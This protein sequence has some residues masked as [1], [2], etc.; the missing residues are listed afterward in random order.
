MLR[1]G[2]SWKLIFTLALVSFSTAYAQELKTR[3]VVLI[4]TDGLRWQEVF[5]GADQSLMNKENGVE[6]VRGLRKDFARDSANESRQALLPFIWG[7]VARKGQIYGNRDKQSFATVTNGLKFSYPGYNEMFTGHADA[8]IKSND[9]GPNPNV[10]V[11]EWLNQLP[12]FHGRVAAFGTWDAFPRI[13]NRERAGF[14]IR[15]GWE[16]PLAASGKLTPAQALLNDLYT[17]TTRLWDDLLY[18]SFLQAAVMDNIQRQHPRVLFV[19]YGETD[20]WAH[21]VRYDQT[22][23]SAHN[24]DHFIAEL[25]K[26]MQGMPEYRDATTF[27]ITTDHGRGSG[28]DWKYHGEGT[29]GA[30]NIWIAVMGPDTSAMGERS[31]L[32]SVTQSQIT[33]TLAAFLG[34]DYKQ[35]VPVAGQRILEVVGKGR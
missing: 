29:D 35:A 28:K 12:E 25:W 8:R 9:Y 24:V 5:H 7:E 15:G 22:L 11:F 10:T 26:T 1:F 33:A 19:G 17:N 18:D 13:F 16:L 27:I 21:K 34:K 3:N 2:H 30:E 14:L 31:Q 4:V 23:R 6:D 32:K 20:E